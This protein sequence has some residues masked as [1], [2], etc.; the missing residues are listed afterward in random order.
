M[1]FDPEHHDVD[2]KTGFHVHKGTEAVVGLAPAPKPKAFVDPDY[3]AWV[4][5]HA[6]HVVRSATGHVSV[7][8]YPVFHID[9]LTQEITVLVEDAADEAKALSDPKAI[10]SEPATA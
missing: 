3:P 8:D 4:K 10:K 7:P 2:P 1:A 5:V 9:R 6:N